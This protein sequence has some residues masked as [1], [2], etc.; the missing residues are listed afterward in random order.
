MTP[1]EYLQAS[2]RTEHTPLF[3]ETGDGLGSAGDDRM[4]SR[5]MHAA[6]GMVTESGEFIDA[7]KKLTI[8]GKPLDK[9]NLVEELGDLQWYIA[10]ACRALDVRFPDKFTSEQA[11]TRDLDAER[12]ALE[13]K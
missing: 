9:V 8:Y 5:L 7:L 11:L 10:L 3:I 2:A 12:G 13:G 4:Y 1:N 6:M